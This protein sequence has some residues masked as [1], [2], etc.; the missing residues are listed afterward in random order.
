MYARTVNTRKLHITDEKS[1]YNSKG[2]LIDYRMSL[3]GQ[4]VIAD[5]DFHQDG[6]NDKVC[7]KCQKLENK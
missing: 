1:S 5:P 6:D 2:K 4:L 3:C 7:V